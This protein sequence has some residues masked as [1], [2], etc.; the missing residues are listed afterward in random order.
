M[1]AERHAG[2]RQSVVLEVIDAVLTSGARMMGGA[3]AQRAVPPRLL[4][5]QVDPFGGVHM[6][7]AG[8]IDAEQLRLLKAAIAELP[9]DPGALSALEQPEGEG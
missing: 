7:R 4:I 9:D 8:T 6:A 2:R 1:S 5:F 3:L